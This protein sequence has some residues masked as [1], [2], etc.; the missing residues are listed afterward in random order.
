MEIPIGR[1]QD[2]TS[3]VFYVNMATSPIWVTETNKADCATIS[4]FVDNAH[5]FCTSNIAE[6]MLD[7][8]L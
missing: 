1:N 2:K 8:S 4:S 6:T 7:S 3:Y 5:R